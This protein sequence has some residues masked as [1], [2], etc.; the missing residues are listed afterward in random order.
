[1]ADSARRESAVVAAPLGPALL[2]ARTMTLMAN[3]SAELA[4][5]KCLL[6]MNP[7]TSM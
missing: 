1:M 7:S 2:T 3:G 4:A 6:S 5:T